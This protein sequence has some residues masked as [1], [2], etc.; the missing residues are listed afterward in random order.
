MLMR[1][2]IFYYFSCTKYHFVMETPSA[3]KTKQNNSS[4]KN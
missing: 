4:V 2:M 1:P 3:K